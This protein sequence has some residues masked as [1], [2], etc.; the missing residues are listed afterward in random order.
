M[1]D[2]TRLALDKLAD[3]C[4]FTISYEGDKEDIRKGKD[5]HE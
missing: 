1:R 5:K 2:G 4:F 3:K